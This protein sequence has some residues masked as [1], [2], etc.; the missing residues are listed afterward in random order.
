[1]GSSFSDSESQLAG[2]LYWREGV[3]HEPI[4]NKKH[5]SKA[6]S[7]KSQRQQQVVSSAGR[8]DLVRFT[9]HC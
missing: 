6:K 5:C 3:S 7:Q 9:H 2:F 4:K 8:V 1:M